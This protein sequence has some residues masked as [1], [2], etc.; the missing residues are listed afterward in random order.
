VLE[1]V[2]GD[3]RS[4]H[5][6]YVNS[7][8]VARGLMREALKPRSVSHSACNEGGTQAAISVALSMQ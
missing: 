8:L 6:Q 3:A 1:D 7:A 2:E 5:V 4:A